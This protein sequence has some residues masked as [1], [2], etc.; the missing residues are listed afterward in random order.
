MALPKEN[1]VFVCIKDYI[2][3]LLN[4]QGA[5]LI[6]EFKSRVLSDTLKYFHNYVI[7]SFL[8]S[9]G[10]IKIFKEVYE[11]IAFLCIVYPY[12]MLCCVCM[13]ISTKQGRIGKHI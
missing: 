1:S 12:K 9:I 2:R 7:P 8:Y 3:H 5:E 10:L 4:S 13:S 11:K 6:I